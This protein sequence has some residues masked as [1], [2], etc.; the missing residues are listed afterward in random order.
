[1][2]CQATAAIYYRFDTDYTIES[3]SSHY[4]N[5]MDNEKNAQVPCPIARALAVVGDAW[6][7]LILRDALAGLSRFDQFRKSLKIAPTILTRRLALLTDEGL[8]EKQLYSERPPREEYV[9]T[10]AGRDF[11]PVLFMIGAWGRRHRAG[12]KMTRFLDAETGTDI[13]PV[14]IDEVTGAK[15]GTRPMVVAGVET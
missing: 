13:V 10:P 2:R 6:S 15:I 4:R 8:L 1:M 14:V 7:M 3:K 11:L 9:L 5:S 12:G